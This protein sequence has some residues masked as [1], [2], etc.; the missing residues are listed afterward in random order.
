MAEQ[1]ILK[2]KFIVVYILIILAAIVLLAA[3]AYYNYT[4]DVSASYFSIFS[5]GV[6]VLAALA[7]LAVFLKYLALTY[8][9]SEHEVIFSEGIITRTTRTIP[10]KKIDNITIKRDI[11]DLILT[12]G[13]VSIET[14]AGP[15]PEIVMKFVDS[16]RLE[17]VEKRLKQLIGKEAKPPE[18]KQPGEA[19]EKPAEEK[20][21][22]KKPKK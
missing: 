2:P 22:K 7:L 9:I 14:P 4:G 17:E 5:F 18:Q 11:R 10:V 3:L 16:G 6:I 21:P 13:S 19:Y 8:K 1:I 15:G 20:K 12:T